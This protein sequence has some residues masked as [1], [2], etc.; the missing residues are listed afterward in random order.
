MGIHSD[1]RIRTLRADI[2]VRA[3]GQA[4][5][6]RWRHFLLVA[7]DGSEG[8]RHPPQLGVCLLLAFRCLGLSRSWVAGRVPPP[9][10]QKQ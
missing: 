9:V 5:A 10:H 7:W 3:P 2:R 4:R 1:W 8:Q 6:C